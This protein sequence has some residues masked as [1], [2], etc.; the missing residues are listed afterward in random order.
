MSVAS[1]A[2]FSTLPAEL[3]VQETKLLNSLLQLADDFVAA[4]P[5]SVNLQ[6]W[7]ARR[8]PREFEARVNGCGL[9]FV[10]SNRMTAPRAPRGGTAPA[11]APQRKPLATIPAAAAPAPVPRAAFTP[12]RLH[13]QPQQLKSQLPTPPAART[14]TG[15][16]APPPKPQ[17]SPPLLPPRS[18]AH[19]RPTFSNSE[20]FFASLP[21]GHFSDLEVDVRAPLITLVKKTNVGQ[22]PLSQ[23]RVELREPLARLLPP[24]VSLEQWIGE[25]LGEEFIV[26]TD[27]GGRPVIKDTM[28]LVPKEERQAAL[29]EREAAFFAALPEDELSEEEQRL[30]QGLLD[31]LADFGDGDPTQDPN[32]PQRYSKAG[33]PLMEAAMHRDPRV[34][35]AKHAFMPKNLH[36]RKWIERRVGQ[37]IEVLNEPEQNCKGGKYIFHYV[38]RME[39]QLLTEKPAAKRQRFD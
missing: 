30:R 8:V 26:D 27:D 4:I 12:S 34:Y 10:P 15:S 31:Y 3:T 13:S 36:L 2:F 22:L 9:V 17:P 20:D 25:R 23:L 24:C 19:P 32:A 35:Y 7:A 29:E 1:Q 38:G 16:R 6:E 33:Y 11:S 28:S 37:E 18:S 5:R 39:A 14:A 21:F